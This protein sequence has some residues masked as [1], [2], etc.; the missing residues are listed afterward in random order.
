[1]GTVHRN[2]I[3]PKKLFYKKVVSF[4]DMTFNEDLIVKWASEHL[5]GHMQ[6]D[7]IEFNGSKGKLNQDVELTAWFQNKADSERFYRQWI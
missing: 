6:Y 3:P 7:Y 5:T 4:S 2:G 1:M